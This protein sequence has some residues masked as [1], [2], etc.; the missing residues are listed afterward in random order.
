MHK[1]LSLH[2]VARIWHVNIWFPF[3]RETSSEV[4]ALYDMNVSIHPPQLLVCLGI[5]VEGYCWRMRRIH[6]FQFQSKPQKVKWGSKHVWS[7]LLFRVYGHCRLIITTLSHSLSF[8]FHISFS[9][10]SWVMN[11]T[12]TVVHGEPYFRIIYKKKKCFE[13]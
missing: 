9:R 4:F 11:L 6:N 8:H 13:K 7:S 12:H 5:S 1:L 2:Q 10:L 3:L